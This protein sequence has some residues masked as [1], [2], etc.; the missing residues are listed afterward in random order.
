M[1]QSVNRH[2]V[3]SIHDV[4]PLTRDSVAG[5]LAELAQWGVGRVSL[6][7]VPDHHR[8][9]NING[10]A[11]FCGW[12]REMV[13]AGHEAVL[14]GYYHQRE[15]REGESARTRF[16]TRHYTAGEGEF[17]DI[18][19]DAARALLERGRQEL[20]LCAGT[21]PE[22]FI[23]PAWLL[24]AEGEKAAR[25]LGFAYTTRLKSV[26]ELGCGR[27]W[28]SQSLCW[29]VRS[30]WR[31]AASMGWNRF[32]FGQ[33]R[34]SALLR[35][36]IHP[37]DGGHAEIWRQIGKLAKKALEDR[38]AVTYGEFFARASGA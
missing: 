35:I 2:L 20:E 31:R 1:A 16:F 12:L 23:A 5:M 13:A 29:S 4:S 26:L 7:V 10:D 37:P 32:L 30:G 36:S 22:G 33:L 11:A 3:V 38:E 9:G 28:E 27:A 15:Q 14:H 25:E 24:S 19:Y 34:G 8:R 18:G 6:L 21:K 17:Y